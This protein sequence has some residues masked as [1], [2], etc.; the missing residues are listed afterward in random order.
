MQRSGSND[1]PGQRTRLWPVLYA[2][3][4]IAW[5]GVIFWLSSVPASGYEGASRYLAW[6]PWRSYFVHGGLYFILC[7]LT[8]RLLYRAKA[9]LPWLTAEQGAVLIST[10]YGLSDEYH[11]TFV[12]GRDFSPLDLLADFLGASVAAAAWPVWGRAL[13]SWR[14]RR[15]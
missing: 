10:L 14:A 11:Q 1:T 12:A 7:V 4:P 5:A 9:R 3:P 13:S 8:L 15:A 6:L 2:V